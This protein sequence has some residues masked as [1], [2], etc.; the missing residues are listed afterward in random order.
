MALIKRISSNNFLFWYKTCCVFWCVYLSLFLPWRCSM[1]FFIKTVLGYTLIGS[2][3]GALATGCNPKYSQSAK[4]SND[5]TPAESSPSNPSSTTTSTGLKMQPISLASFSVDGKRT[6]QEGSDGTSKISISLPNELK[7]AK[8]IDI[9]AS[10]SPDFKNNKSPT[11]KIQIHC[12]EK[13]CTFKDLGSN[14]I[15][16]MDQVKFIQFFYRFY[17]T[18]AQNIAAKMDPQPNQL[19]L[20]GNPYDNLLPPRPWGELEW[21]LVTC[22]Y[23]YAVLFVFLTAV[24]SRVCIRN[25]VYMARL[26]KPLETAAATIVPEIQLNEIVIN[27]AP[28]QVVRNTN[29]SDEEV[30]FP[31]FP[32]K[33]DLNELGKDFKRE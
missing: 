6:V 19:S 5:S 23:L 29:G 3:I 24:I 11:F 15:L 4:N 8:S 17:N 22:L 21:A 20:S 30:A 2:L 33:H 28:A 9:D 12:A 1:S 13:G 27:S 31:G 18:I 7:N 32:W 16:A 14:P 26:I 25:A 10:W